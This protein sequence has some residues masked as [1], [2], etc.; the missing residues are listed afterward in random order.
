MYISMTGFSSSYI[1]REWGTISL[2]L[3]SVNHRYQEIFIRLPRELTS[4]EP[5]FHQKLRKLYRRGKINARVELNWAAS[6]LAV[7]INKEVLASYSRE[8]SEI[9]KTLGAPADESVISMDALINLPGVLDSQAFSGTFGY[10]YDETEKLLLALL[11]MGA[12]DWQDMRRI[13]GSHLEKAI[14]AHLSDFEKLVQEISVKW[15]TARDASFISM[16]ER[17]SRI[18]EAIGIDLPGDSRFAQEAVFMADKWDISEEIERLG[19]HITKFIESGASDEPV[20][21]KLDF[22]V[23]EINREINTINSK[24]SDSDIRWLAVEAKTISEKIREQIQNLE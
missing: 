16:T 12:A 22:L 10:D 1:E 11:E 2:A 8:I 7:S 4:W 13:E 6:A 15:E 18:I 23:Q 21:R 20:G 17:V 5:W 3:S 9:R 24:I 19:S 14:L